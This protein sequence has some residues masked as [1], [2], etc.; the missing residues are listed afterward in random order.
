MMQHPARLDRVEGAVEGCKLD[1]ISLRIFDI[2]NTEHPRHSLRITQACE[3]EIDREHACIW[4]TAR[5]ND[6]LLARAATRD[7]NVGL[8]V[9]FPAVERSRGEQR[10]QIFAHT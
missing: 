3:A 4:E 5:R 8:A 1:N 9:A 6:R 7:E 2:V 10:T